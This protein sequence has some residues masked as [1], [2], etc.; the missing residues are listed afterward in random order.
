MDTFIPFGT[1]TASGDVGGAIPPHPDKVAW[2]RDNF[3]PHFENWVVKPINR[4]VPSE[5]AL[6][7]FIFMSCT[8]DYLAAFLRGES[9]R[10][11]DRDS[12]MKFICDYFP[13]GRYDAAALYDSLRNGL[14]HLFTIKGKKY[15]LTHNQPSLHLKTDSKGQIVLNAENFRDDLLGAK[16][17]YFTAVQ[18]SAALL[19]KLEERLSRDGFLGPSDIP[20]A[21]LDRRAKPDRC[22]I[23]LYIVHHFSGVFMN[24][25]RSGHRTSEPLYRGG[26]RLGTSSQ[27]GG[28]GVDDAF[29]LGG[30]H[31][32]RSHCFGVYCICNRLRCFPASR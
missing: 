12:Y 32:N 30:R 2:F 9:T 10:G 21:C 16:E 27:C 11:K 24:G 31:E 18:A 7:G 14:V 15:V 26:R 25:G 8:I 17:K 5:D 29:Q 13:Q 6:I 22:G 23:S 1:V 20:Q 28:L 4:L 19:D 3:R